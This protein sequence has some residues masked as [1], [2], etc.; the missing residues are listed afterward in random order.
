M[1]LRNQSTN[2]F[3]SSFLPG[4]KVPMIGVSMIMLVACV[5]PFILTVAKSVDPYFIGNCTEAIMND[6]SCSQFSFDLDNA[7][8]TFVECVGQELLA[9]NLLIFCLPTEASILPQIGLFHTL[10]LSLMSS[11]VFYSEPANYA[12]EVF[13]PNLKASCSG[14][15]CAF[16]YVRTVYGSSLGYMFLGAVLLLVLGISI[17]YIAIYPIPI[18]IRLR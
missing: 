1:S 6:T 14:N 7:N 5:S 18:L 8:S 17:S 4:Y 13:V 9:T 11:V 10:S 12:T 16:D 15:S 2:F 3:L